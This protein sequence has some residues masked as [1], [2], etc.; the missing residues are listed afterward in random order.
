MS[1]VRRARKNTTHWRMLHWAVAASRSRLPPRE[2]STSG[3]GAELA[4]LEDP[5]GRVLGG[6]K[7][8]VAVLPDEGLRAVAG[9]RVHVLPQV[10]GEKAA[11]G[12]LPEPGRNLLRLA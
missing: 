9:H 4:R 6:R 12:I 11:L 7:V 2:A 8:G 3:P 5:P 10:A 1:G